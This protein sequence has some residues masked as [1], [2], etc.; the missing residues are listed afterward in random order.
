MQVSGHSAV[1]TG[2]ASGLGAGLIMVPLLSMILTTDLVPGPTIFAS[3]ALSL[4]MTIAGR[5]HIEFAL[6][7]WVLAGTVIGTIAAAWFIAHVLATSLGSG[8]ILIHAASGDWLSPPG[9]VLLLRVWTTRRGNIVFL[10]RWQRPD[11]LT[12]GF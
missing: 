7:N 3:L 8:L 11:R 5:Q 4:S 2:G 10:I 6:T 12:H 9:I 1:V